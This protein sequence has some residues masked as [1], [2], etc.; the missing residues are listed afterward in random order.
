V[1]LPR[2]HANPPRPGPQRDIA[3][4]ADGL[5]F[6]LFS[7]AGG[8]APAAAEAP[9]ATKPARPVRWRSA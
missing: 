8:F 3:V 7:T 9:S 5:T 4:A 2:A 6:F 1:G